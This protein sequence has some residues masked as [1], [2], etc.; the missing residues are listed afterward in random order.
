MRAARPLLLIQDAGGLNTVTFSL[1]ANSKRAARPLQAL[2]IVIQ[3]GPRWKVR[4]GGEGPEGAAGPRAGSRTAWEGWSR[5]GALRA[6]ALHRR[7][8]SRNCGGREGPGRGWGRGPHHQ[9]DPR[10]FARE[11]GRFW[12]VSGRRC[13]AGEGLGV[14]EKWK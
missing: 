6:Q 3:K 2:H 8:T 4:A 12:R 11:G 1:G 13:G 14:G 7:E 5:D 9:F 10:G